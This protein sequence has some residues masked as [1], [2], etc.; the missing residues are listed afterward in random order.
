[1]RPA[2]AAQ[3]LGGA[4]QHDPL[5]HRNRAQPVDIG[6]RHDA[7]VEMRQEPGLAQHQLR[8]LGEVGERGLVAEPGQRLARRAVAQ[9]GLVAQREQRLA[10]AGARAGAGDR[11]HLLGVEIGGLAAARRMREGAVVADVAAQLGQRD[12]HLARIGDEAAVARVAQC[13]RDPHQRP[14]VGGSRRAPA[15]PSAESTLPRRAP[16]VRISSVVIR[17]DLLATRHHAFL[18]EYGPGSGRRSGPHKGQQDPRDCR[19][20]GRCPGRCS[21]FGRMPHASAACKMRE[22]TV[23]A[24]AQRHRVGRRAE[25]SR[26]SRARHATERS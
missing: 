7:G 21:T 16:G 10:A 12:E 14:W 22:E 13:R 4:L 9:F 5:R 8:H 24:K 6:P 3:P 23:L 18:R 11:Q 17:E 19:C 26:S 15:P 25:R 2:A 20:R 1:M